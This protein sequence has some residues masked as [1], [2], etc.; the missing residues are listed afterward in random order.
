MRASRA[1]Q[2][3]RGG[4]VRARE[5]KTGEVRRGGSRVGRS[6][7]REGKY[8]GAGREEREK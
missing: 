8:L 5:V 6:W 3:N 4:K 2:V 1:V 7:G